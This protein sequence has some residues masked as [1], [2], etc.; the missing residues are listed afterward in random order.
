MFL[1]PVQKYKSVFSE[2][3]AKTEKANNH[4]TTKA[5]NKYKAVWNSINNEL[6]VS[7]KKESA[8]IK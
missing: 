2:V 8:V 3:V 6:G 1:G 7:I 4:H 5:S